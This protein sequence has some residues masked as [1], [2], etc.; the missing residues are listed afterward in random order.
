MTDLISKKLRHC[1]QPS[2]WPYLDEEEVETILRR[3][4]H[5]IDHAKVETDPI[6]HSIHLD[7][8]IDLTDCREGKIRHALPGVVSRCAVICFN[9][10]STITLK[11]Q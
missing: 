6:K 4:A 7:S 11:R 3:T 8:G 9:R 1:T 2:S 5:E 10:K